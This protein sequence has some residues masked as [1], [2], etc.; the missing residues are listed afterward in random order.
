MCWAFFRLQSS[1]TVAVHALDQYWSAQ[2]LGF[3]D[4][5][6]NRSSYRWICSFK[7]GIVV[8][9]TLKILYF[10]KIPPKYH[11][12]S[13]AARSRIP[14]NTIFS[15]KKNDIFFVG[16]LRKRMLVSFVVDFQIYLEQ[17]L[18]YFWKIKVGSSYVHYLSYKNVFFLLQ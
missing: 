18:N 16:I 6:P 17:K 11:I 14:K 8:K 15:A 13:P 12:F 9:N 1:R 4:G 2:D 5:I 3:C 10:L 7:G